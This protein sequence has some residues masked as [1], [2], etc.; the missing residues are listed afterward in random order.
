MKSIVKSLKFKTLTKLLKEMKKDRTQY[1]LE[2]RD[3]VSENTTHGPSSHCI[4]MKS[5]G[6][7]GPV[8]DFCCLSPFGQRILRSYRYINILSSFRFDILRVRRAGHLGFAVLLCSSKS[9]IQAIL[10]I[11]KST[12][13]PSLLKLFTPSQIPLI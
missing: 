11:K 5:M 12:S 3:I 10:T 13:G 1:F 9:F 4:G 6:P 8:R 7:I 2:D